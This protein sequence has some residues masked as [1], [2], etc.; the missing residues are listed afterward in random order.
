MFPLLLKARIRAFL[1]FHHGHDQPSAAAAHAAHGRATSSEDFEDHHQDEHPHERLVM[2]MANM[3]L[4]T[5]IT[6]QSPQS[7]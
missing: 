4:N 5:P 6:G 2:V 3:T 7:R 1:S